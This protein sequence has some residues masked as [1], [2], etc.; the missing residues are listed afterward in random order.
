MRNLVDILDLTTA[1]ID[2]LISV[3]SDII[4]RPEAYAE[5]AK[6]KILGTLFFEPSTRTRLSFTSAMMSLGGSVL[7]FDQA[8]STS[9]SK[10]ETVADTIRMVSA[11]AD[12]IAMRHP[13]EG[14]PVVAS[15]VATVP[16]INAGDGG[17]YHPTQTLTDLLTIKR[18]LGRLDNLTVGI[19]GDLKYGR[20]V[21]S[22]ISAMSRYEGVKFV[23]IS[24]EELKL[25]EYVKEEFLGEGKSPYVETTDLEGAIPELDILYMTRIQAERFADR[26]EYER[27]KDSYILTAAK[28]RTAKPTL[29]VMHPLPR[30][31]EIDVDVDDD[32]RAHY[33]EQAANGRFIRM[34]LILMLLDTKGVD[35]RRLHGVENKHL[36]CLNPHCLSRSERGIKKL[37][38]GE[39]CIYCDQKAIKVNC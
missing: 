18:K 23:L 10:G 25:P 20:T 17:H 31:N 15:A 34:A 7:G 16:V 39:R 2:G 19:A 3:A 6:G 27:L 29:S 1:E 35:D 36:E 26:Q 38:E 14:A 13:K 32:P 30:V 4:D 5:R 11:Y 28:L 24:P 9:V 37:F 12:I 22:L 21:H 33:F 8:G